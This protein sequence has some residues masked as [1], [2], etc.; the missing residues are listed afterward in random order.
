LRVQDWHQ[1]PL[2]GGSYRREH[3]TERRGAQ[4]THQ[5]SSVQPG[6]PVCHDADPDH[7]PLD[8]SSQSTYLRTGS[9]TAIFLLRTGW[10]M[11]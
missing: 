1:P 8:K 9:K 6:N 4:A 3:R 11:L 5:F 10:L 7:F 2:L